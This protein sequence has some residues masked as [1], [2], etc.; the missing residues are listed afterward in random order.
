MNNW[1]LSEIG[2]KCRASIS[3]IVQRKRYE[4]LLP[5]GTDTWNKYIG[6]KHKNKTDILQ[7]KF[8]G[9]SSK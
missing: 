9:A 6:T 7:S 4:D 8:V 2:S 3:A 1:P 5:H